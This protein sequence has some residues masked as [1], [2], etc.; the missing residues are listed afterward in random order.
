MRYLNISQISSMFAMSRQVVRKK[1]INAK[2]KPS[3]K[4]DRQV[5]LYDM[6]KVGPVY[7]E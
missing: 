6:T 4:N 7:L 5:D 3:M 1:I 2:V